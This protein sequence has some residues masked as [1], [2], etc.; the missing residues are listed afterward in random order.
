MNNNMW[1]DQNRE[2]DHRQ[3]QT[4]ASWPLIII[5]FIFFWPLGL[6]LLYRRLRRRKYT[7]GARKASGIMGFVLLFIGAIIFADVLDSLMHFGF[8]ALEIDTLV[9][10]AFF[11]IGG[12]WI[13]SSGRGLN[14]MEKY[15]QKYA[16]V[17]GSRETVSIREVAEAMGVSLRRAVHDL[18]RMVDKGFFG[19]AAFIDKKL[20]YLMRSTDGYNCVDLE[21]DESAPKQAA[22][23]DRFT[24]TL[25]EIRSLND[26]IVDAE[27][28]RKIEQVESIT[29]KIFR[30]TEDDPAKL[31][32][33]R[34][35]LNYYLPT[36]L[37]LMRTYSQLERQGETGENIRTAKAKIESILDELIQGFQRILDHLYRE[38]VMDISADIEVLERMMAKDGFSD[39]NRIQFERE[40]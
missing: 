3:K 35:F 7:G 16:N 2:V 21:E 8:W 37:K 30:A 36:T 10:G 24:A 40:D 23:P 18:E 4:V 13:L 9:V 1:E 17:V 38:D 20:Y 6:F 25:R 5:C 19:P 29:A 39:K 22:E 31:E 32:D 26:Q 14:R 28:S 15:Y 27:V 34:S 33:I 12:L 11:L